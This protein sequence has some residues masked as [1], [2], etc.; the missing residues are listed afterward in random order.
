M[1]FLSKLSQ[2]EIS[3][4][5]LQVGN[6]EALHRL[7]L[8]AGNCTHNKGFRAEP[9]REEGLEHRCLQNQVLSEGS[10]PEMALLPLDPTLQ[11]SACI[12][13]LQGSCKKVIINKGPG[14]VSLGGAEILHC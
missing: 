9:Y 6:E 1:G 3:P 8:G 12:Q 5:L 11:A 2:S 7:L 10:V 14:S 13:I 4:E